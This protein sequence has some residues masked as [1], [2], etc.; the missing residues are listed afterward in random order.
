MNNCQTI[1][2]KAEAARRVGLSIRHCERLEAAGRFPRRIRVS[3]NA[4]GW[5]ESEIQGFIAERIAASRSE[6]RAA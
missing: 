4:S 1:L 2:R 3:D 6:P 5:L